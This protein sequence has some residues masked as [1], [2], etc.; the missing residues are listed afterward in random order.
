MTVW[1]KRYNWYTTWTC[2][3]VLL[4]TASTSCSS[5]NCETRRTPHI[6]H[7]A[8]TGQWR[9]SRTMQFKHTQP[10]NLARVLS[11][12]VSPIQSPHSPTCSQLKKIPWSKYWKEMKSN[13]MVALSLSRHDHRPSQRVIS[14]ISTLC[15]SLKTPYFTPGMASVGRNS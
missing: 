6:M 11:D 1:K 3:K 8:W 9:I 10:F 15:P 7:Q 14:A 2:M 4:I 12:L 5:G 13:R